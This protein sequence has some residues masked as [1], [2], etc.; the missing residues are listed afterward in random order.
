ML[1]SLSSSSVVERTKATYRLSYEHFCDP[2]IKASA[3]INLASDDPDLVEI[4]IMR[5]LI[6]GKD[7]LSA[8]TVRD[9]LT[10][11]PIDELVFCAAVGALTNLARDCRETALPTLHALEVVPRQ[12][13][14][15]GRE[16]LL[17]KAVAELR[18]L[19]S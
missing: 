6:R 13:V 4:T 14:H 15:N 1:D 9:L 7:A 5:L 2:R 12:N 16:G 10:D 8:Q 19:T 3:R 11:D 17:A 18:H